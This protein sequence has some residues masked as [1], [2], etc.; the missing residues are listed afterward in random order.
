MHELDSVD[1]VVVEVA[2][3][4]VEESVEEAVEESV[5]DAAEESVEEAVEEAAE[6]FT[7]V[8]KTGLKTTPHIVHACGKLFFK[9]LLPF[10]TRSKQRSSIEFVLESGFVRTTCSCSFGTK[11]RSKS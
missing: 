3:E 8:L 2:E 10:F 1:E 5:E 11:V 9:Q 7:T 6:E 4:V